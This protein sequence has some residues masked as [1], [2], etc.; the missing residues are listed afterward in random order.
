MQV[1]VDT[2]ILPDGVVVLLNHSCDPNCGLLIR[3][4]VK[5]IEA[6]ALRPIQAGEELTFDYETFE[7][8]IEHLTGPCLCGSKKCRGRLTGYSHLPAEVKARYGE[9]IAEYLRALEG[10]VTVPVGA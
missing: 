3:S 9:F 5:E 1:D 6:K 7:Y 4:G 2:H 8:E 10:E